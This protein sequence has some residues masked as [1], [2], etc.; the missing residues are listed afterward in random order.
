LDQS[1]H[2][3]AS[4]DLLTQLEAFSELTSLGHDRRR[5]QELAPKIIELLESIRRL[6]AVDVEGYEMA[7]NYETWSVDR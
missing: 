2:L 3:S 6:R 5:L 7:V 4:E 1:Q